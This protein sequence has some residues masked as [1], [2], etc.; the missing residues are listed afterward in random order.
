MMPA[1]T[2]QTELDRRA[3]IRLSAARNDLVEKLET[4][5]MCT[6]MEA[7]QKKTAR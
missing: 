3:I 2:G 4:T 6:A 1:P 5:S 7:K